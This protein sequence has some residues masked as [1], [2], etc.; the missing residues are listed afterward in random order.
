[1]KGDKTTRLYGWLSGLLVLMI[2]ITI[3]M[4]MISL[5]HIKQ[6]LVMTT[7]HSLA[8]ASDSIA[9][10]IDRV[11]FERYSSVISMAQAE[12]L[13]QQHA[14][15]T[16]SYLVAMKRKFPLYDWLEVT[17]AQGRVT[18][19][20]DLGMLGEDRSQDPWFQYVPPSRV[21]SYPKC[22]VF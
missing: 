8:L 13:Q 7:G 15:E 19:S 2:V 4:G 11:L 10:Q 1:M 21:S 22:R 3:T 18:V 5:R 9:G 17:D 14:T 6:E 20:T 12:P 16:W